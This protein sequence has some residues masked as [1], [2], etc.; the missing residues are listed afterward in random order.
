MVEIGPVVLNEIFLKS[1]QHQ[2]TQTINSFDRGKTKKFCVEDAIL[3]T[4][5][6]QT[7][8]LNYFKKDYFW[9]CRQDELI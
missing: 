1:L 9:N 3:L 5:K 7:I 4:A 6:F 2:M 8:W